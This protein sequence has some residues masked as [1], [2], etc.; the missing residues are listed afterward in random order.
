M[1][2]ESFSL[3]CDAMSVDGGSRLARA[4]DRN[5]TLRS[6]NLCSFDHA[7]GEEGYEAD[8]DGSTVAGESQGSVL[9]M[10]AAFAE[11]LRMNFCLQGLTLDFPQAGLPKDEADSQIDPL[12]EMLAA[13]EVGLDRNRQLLEGLTAWRPLALLARCGEHDGFR[14][15]TSRDFRSCVMS[16]FVSPQLRATV[17]F[18]PEVAP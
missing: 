10:A 9:T 16:Y 11:T 17:R 6:F 13:I 8:S 1:Q 18:F 7:D 4:L 14:S 15:L 2:L 12:D 3:Q 5:E